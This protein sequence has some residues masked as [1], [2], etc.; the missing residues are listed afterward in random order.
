VTLPS[1]RELTLGDAEA[2]A[3]LVRALQADIGYRPTVNPA[4]VRE[5]MQWGDLADDS[6]AF[7][8]DGRLLAL[9]WVFKHGEIV[10]GGGFVHPDARGRGLGTE[11]VERSEEWA[12]RKGFGTLHAVVYGRDDAGHALLRG[13]GYREVRRFF[14][15]VMDLDRPPAAPSP[16]AGV[17]IAPFELSDART[18]HDTIVDAFRGEWGFAP[19]SFEE[20]RRRRVDEAD[21]SLYFLAWDGAEAAGAIRCVT[22]SSTDGF[23]GALG[24]REA[25]RRRGL[26]EALLL[27]A[28]AEMQRR[29]LAVV[30]LGVDSENPTGATRLYERVGMAIAT[31]DVVYERTLT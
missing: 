10:D 15:L 13:R 23:V 26:G 30:R 25:W 17:R 31:E 14:E 4:E 16:P 21:T 24:V 22:P 5:W 19:M 20:W 18:F 1:A 2:G 27:H 7:E 12:R 9:G 28:F 6:W 8:E 11:L 29:G 3:E